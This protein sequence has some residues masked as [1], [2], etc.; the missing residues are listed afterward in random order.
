[1]KQRSGLRDESQLTGLRDYMLFLEQTY[2]I[3][4]EGRLGTAQGVDLVIGVGIHLSRQ[5]FS[6]RVC[7]FS[8]RV[9]PTEGRECR[10]SL[11]L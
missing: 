11:F 3:Q 8:D 10:R 5:S 7:L 4:L 6:A 1:M 9:C 2:D